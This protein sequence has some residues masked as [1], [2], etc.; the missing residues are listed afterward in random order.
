MATISSSLGRH[1]DIRPWHYRTPSPPRRAVEPISPFFAC[2]SPRTFERAPPPA[3]LQLENKQQ[4]HYTSRNGGSRN[5]PDEDGGHGHGRSGSTID[6]L[7][8]IALATSPT[9]SQ[10]SYG[11]SSPSSTSAT[12]LFSWDVREWPVEPPKKRPRLEKNPSPIYRHQHSHHRT[13]S[14]PGTGLSSVSD[15][16]KIDAELLL[17]FARPSTAHHPESPAEKMMG[18]DSGHVGLTE[19]TPASR[20]HHEPCIPSR[21]RSQSDGSVMSRPFIQVVRPNAAS[22][23]PPSLRVTD[24]VAEEGNGELRLDEKNTKTEN[25]RSDEG[26]QEASCAACNRVRLPGNSHDGDGEDQDVT[27]INCDGCERWFHISCAGFENDRQVRAVDK[28]IC[29]ECRPIHGPTTFV[30]KSSRART[31]I[32]YAGLHQGLVKSTA[33]NMEH[34]YIEPIKRGQIRF[35]PEKFP[36]MRPELVSAEHFAHGDGMLER[37]SYRPV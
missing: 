25:M 28:F 2:D 13:I 4:H 36:R 22:Y 12:P 34:H 37:S 17:N 3:P 11:P 31:A 26:E 19:Q 10:H 15:S 1:N 9:F 8:T 29:N 23:S 21:T 20:S 33:D 5:V 24:Q 16:M 6:T 7:A 14:G 18:M 32:D 27:W 35:V 30:R